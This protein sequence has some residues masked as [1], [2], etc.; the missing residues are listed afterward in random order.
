MSFYTLNNREYISFPFVPSQNRLPRLMKFPFEQP[1]E[2]EPKSEF[3]QLVL[4]SLKQVNDLQNK[5][6]SLTEKMIA[7]PD[8]VDVHDITI[9]LA[10]AQ[11]SLSITK[12]V[13]DRAIR[14]Y[15]E[16]VSLS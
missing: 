1:K 14:A 9:A 10:Q 11:M 12:E 3:N 7:E 5:P 16:I 2:V 15:R 4:N 8:A 13:F 6:Y